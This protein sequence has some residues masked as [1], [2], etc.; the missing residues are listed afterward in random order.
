MDRPEKP[1]LLHLTE[2]LMFASRVQAAVE[3]RGVGVRTEM[4]WSG[5]DLGPDVRAV[6][7][8]LQLPDIPWEE[9]PE[10]IATAGRPVWIAYGPHVLTDRLEAARRAGFP[11]VLPRGKLIPWLQQLV[12]AWQDGRG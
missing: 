5:R 9:L 4:R 6:V 2:N 1:L 12:T 10:A 7:L 11:H 3:C 8:D